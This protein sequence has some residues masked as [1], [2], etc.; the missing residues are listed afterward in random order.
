MTENCM[1]HADLDAIDVSM[2]EAITISVDL[3]FV[4][5][6]DQRD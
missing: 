1:L 5:G 6:D 2:E 4:A 3:H